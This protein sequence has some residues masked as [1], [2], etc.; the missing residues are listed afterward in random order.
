[1]S[2]GQQ[3]NDIREIRLRKFLRLNER[4]VL[5]G[6]KVLNDYIVFGPWLMALD[7]Y[8]SPYYDLVEYLYEETDL[9]NSVSDLNDLRNMKISDLLAYMTADTAEY[10]E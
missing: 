2:R 7:D 1:M 5:D 3:E 4:T 6:S 8:F 9:F 10:F